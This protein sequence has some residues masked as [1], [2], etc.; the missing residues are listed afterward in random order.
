[1]NKMINLNTSITKM[2]ALGTIAAVGF[3]PLAA[4]A[5]TQSQLKNRQKQKNTWRNLGLAGAAVGVYG[6]LK[7]DKVL[8]IA[9]LGGGAYSAWR[10]EQDRK[11]QSNMERQR[12]QLFSR[13]SIVRNGHRYNRKTVW[14]NGKKYYQFVRAN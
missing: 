7:G 6:L 14:K 5:Q 1:M 12:A 10:Y 3:A 4:N 11:S 13:R 8:T 2:V 9:G